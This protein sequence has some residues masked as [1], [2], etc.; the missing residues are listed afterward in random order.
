M[1]S[2]VDAG[3]RLALVPTLQYHHLHLAGLHSPLPFYT[4]DTE[5]T[6]DQTEAVSLLQHMSDLCMV[7]FIYHLPGSQSPQRLKAALLVR[8]RMVLVKMTWR[9]GSPGWRRRASR[10]R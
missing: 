6:S 10:T 1:D 9:V 2:N 8:K 4:P 3:H 7:V 5:S